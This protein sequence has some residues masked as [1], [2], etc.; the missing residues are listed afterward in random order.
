MAARAAEALR[1]NADAVVAVRRRGAVVGHADSATGPAAGPATGTTGRRRDVTART[2]GAALAYGGN[3][4]DVVIGRRDGAIVDRGRRAT[5]AAAGA[6]AAVAARCRDRA[7]I[8]AATAEAVDEK[9]RAAVADIDRAVIGNGRIAAR[10]AI[11]GIT[12]NAG[13]VAAT[14]AQ[15]AAALSVKPV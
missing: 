14:A 3:T 1:Q 15:G 9:T 10:A 8:A 12:T 4:D 2:T 7:A 6:I 11:A 13:N 5:R